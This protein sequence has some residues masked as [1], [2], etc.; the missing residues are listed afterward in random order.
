MKIIFFLYSMINFFIEKTNKI[1]NLNIL[2]KLNKKKK[3][4]K[5]K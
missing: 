2:K 4:V 5:I 1:D 3:K